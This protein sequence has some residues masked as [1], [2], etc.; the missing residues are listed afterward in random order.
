MRQVITKYRSHYVPYRGQP[1]RLTHSDQLLLNLK[2]F[3]ERIYG[4]NI[5]HQVLPHFQRPDVVYCFDE[6]GNS[7]T[8]K[9]LDCLPPLY[10]GVIVTKEYLLSKKTEFA[11]NIDKFRMVAVILGGWNFYLR[12]TKIPTGGLRMKMEQLEMIGYQPILIH[13]DDWLHMK[14]SEKEKLFEREIKRPLE[15]K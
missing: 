3:L 8:D 2:E 1:Y 6:N 13:W 4:V 11:D 9:L 10:D 5:L 12:G 14:M 7:V 15:P